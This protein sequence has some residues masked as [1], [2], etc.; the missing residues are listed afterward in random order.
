MMA[1]ED[2]MRVLARDLNKAKIIEGSARTSAARA[3]VAV[4]DASAL[5]R[6]LQ[7]EMDK[8]VRKLVEEA[9]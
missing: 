6:K 9:A 7:S 5:V 2:Q 4:D 3:E 1:T 8:L